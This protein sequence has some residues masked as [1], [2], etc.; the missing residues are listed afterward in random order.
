MQSLSEVNVRYP[1]QTKK[2]YQKAK[3]AFATFAHALLGE[4]KWCPISKE[5][6]FLENYVFMSTLITFV[7]NGGNIQDQVLLQS[8][9]EQNNERAYDYPKLFRLHRT[10]EEDNRYLKTP[11]FLL[12]VRNEYDQVYRQHIS[13]IIQNI[14]EMNVYL[15]KNLLRFIFHDN[16]LSFVSS[17]ED[18]NTLLGESSKF[19][20][21]LLIEE[22]KNFF[23]FRI[24]CN[25]HCRSFA[26]A[27]AAFDH[28]KRSHPSY[29]DQS[30]IADNMDARYQM[31]VRDANNVS[32]PIIQSLTRDV[33]FC[34]N[35][36]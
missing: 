1:C 20:I 10:L 25:T 22:L 33:D 21:N 19:A 24:I 3:M 8:L 23:E 28:A 16:D 35:N 7:K 26:S 29:V 12:E 17:V 11:T 13:A 30:V 4:G 2:R 15:K 34:I 5:K 27:E 18:P 32:D 36:H 14:V 6:R 9:I 31:G